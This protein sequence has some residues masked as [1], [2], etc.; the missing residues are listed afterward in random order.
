M[1]PRTSTALLI[2][3][4]L[5]PAVTCTEC[6][7]E[8][9][10]PASAREALAVLCPGRVAL[11]PAFDR[12]ARR[13]HVPA[14]LLVAQARNETGCAP[15]AVNANGIDVG[16]LQVRVGSHAARGR[17]VEQLKNP[18][19][20]IPLAARH[21]ARCLALC[22]DYAGA[23]GVYAGWKTCSQGSASGYARRVLGFL[24]EVEGVKRS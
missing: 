5:S 2:A 24:N 12:A 3:V 21:L 17:T 8:A 9:S 14:T 16:I 19:I 23:L 15:D 7:A 11:A 18:A 13:F 20:N 4:M 22:R 1:R 10:E 6:S